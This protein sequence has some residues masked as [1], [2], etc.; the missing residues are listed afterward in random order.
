MSDKCVPTINA[1]TRYAM[2]RIELVRDGFEDYLT[3]GV[4]DNKPLEKT[5][6]N[7]F[8]EDILHLHTQVKSLNQPSRKEPWP[9]SQIALNKFVKQWEGEGGI[10]GAA[11]AKL[12]FHVLLC[13]FHVKKAWSKSFQPKFE[14]SFH[15]NSTYASL[16]GWL[17][18]ESQ[19]TFDEIYE[20]LKEKVQAEGV[21]RGGSA[22]VD[23]ALKY[24]KGW[25]SEGVMWARFG[26]MFDHNEMETN[27]LL[28]RWWGTL[29]YTEF[30]GRRNKSAFRLF[31]TVA[32][33]GTADGESGTPIGRLWDQETQGKDA[34][35]FMHC[36]AV[37]L[38][39]CVLVFPSLLST[40]KKKRR[41]DLPQQTRNNAMYLPSVWQVAYETDR[42]QSYLRN[43]GN[44]TFAVGGCGGTLLLAPWYAPLPY[45]DPS[46]MCS[47]CARFATMAT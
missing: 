7:G 30:G 2:D 41:K 5:K 13:E 29:K 16:C 6:A 32:G 40:G 36:V 24:L 33:N 25:Y 38:C 28:E 46:R 17:S 21:I 14:S 37:V 18:A 27:N 1:L 44:F 22:K 26:R 23:A 8:F 31:L 39:P 47:R 12:E 11:V 20:I 10:I 19:E 43:Q 3:S 45:T 9:K 35:C 15:W 4:L 34:H 42:L